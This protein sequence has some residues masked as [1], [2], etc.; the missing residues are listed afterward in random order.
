MM[1]TSLSRDGAYLGSTISEYRD[2]A[3]LGKRDI[4][5]SRWGFYGEAK[6][7]CIAMELTWQGSRISVEW[8][9][10]QG[11]PDTGHREAQPIRPNP[12]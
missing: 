9:C 4:R 11:E 10:Y 1:K 12:A 2:G 5:Q 6:Y 7:S 3:D 8:D